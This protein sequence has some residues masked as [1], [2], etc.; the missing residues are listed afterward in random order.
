MNELRPVEFQWDQR[1]WYENGK[2]DGT[3]CGEIDLGFIAQDILSCSNRES[4]RIVN[5][6]NTE[7]Y[8]VAPARLLPLI[9]ASIQELDKKL[10]YILSRME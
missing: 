5:T 3:K 2:P 8:E 1:E 4:Y 6:D 10:N 9:V 7:R